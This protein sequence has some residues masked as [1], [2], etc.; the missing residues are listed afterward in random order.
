VPTPTTSLPLS[1]RHLLAHIH[2][3]LFC[4]HRSIPSFCDAQATNRHRAATPPGRSRYHVT[5]L[6]GTF[7]VPRDPQNPQ[8]ARAIAPSYFPLILPPI[9]SSAVLKFSEEPLAIN[10][11]Q[12][13]PH[14]RALQYSTHPLRVGFT[15]VSQGINTHFDG[16]GTIF[17]HT[18][19]RSPLSG[20]GPSG[21]RAPYFAVTYALGTSRYPSA[22]FSV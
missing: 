15:S 14:F 9:H 19:I 5:A 11:L 22:L 3:S 12:I 7:Y 21:K 2:R 8:P 18:Q 16:I 4:P 13:I 6:P 1:P 20:S 10:A 17:L